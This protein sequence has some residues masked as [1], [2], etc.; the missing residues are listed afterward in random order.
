MDAYHIALFV[1]ILAL[2]AAAAASA[3]AHLA[4]ARRG[5]ARTVGEMLD[6]HSTLVAVSKVFPLALA[7]FVLTGGYMLSVNHAQV[8][9]TGF[10][11]AG[12]TGVA[13]LLMSGIFLGTKGKALQVM[14]EEKAA[15]GADQPAPRLRPPGMIAA[16]PRINLFI[17]LSVAFDMVT[18][19]ASVASALTVIAIGIVV[20]LAV[21]LVR[22]EA[23]A[24]EQAAA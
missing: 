1:H 21:G 17:A 20:A 14:L 3:V 18:K 12:L 22:R 11:V 15:Q 5:R 8:W 23:P 7:V 19:P 4:V 9:S 2:L 6:W 16:L 24:A 13:L 10:V